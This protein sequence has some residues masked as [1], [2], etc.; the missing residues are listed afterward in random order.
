MW[1]CQLAMNEVTR[2]LNALQEKDLTAT[3]QLLP[4]IYDE[5]RRLARFKMASESADHTLQPT[6]LVHE[7]WLRL[8][9]SERQ[10]WA[11]RAHFFGAAAEA[12][13]RILIDRARRK[14]ASRH[15]GGYGDAATLYRQAAALHR[16]NAETG[17]QPMASSNRAQPLDLP[18]PK[19]ADANDQGFLT[20]GVG[21]C[22]AFVQQSSSALN[23]RSGGT[24]S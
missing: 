3:D 17:Q 14:L 6:A 20:G 1:Q 15:G 2:I 13:R 9:D 23:T 19:R 4:A 21:S 5:L 12:M 24:T 11:H 8:G 16:R 10:T 22:P 7:A 18:P